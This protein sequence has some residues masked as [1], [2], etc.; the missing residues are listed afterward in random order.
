[1]QTESFADW[2]EQMLKI[3]EAEVR[4]AARVIRSGKL[5][6]YGDGSASGES[7]CA[8]LERELAK[9]MGVEYALVVTSGTAALICAMAGMGI[10]PGDE[11]IVPGYTFMAS[12]LA[13]LAVGAIPVIADIDES[14]TLDPKDVEAKISPRTRAIMPVDMIGLPADMGAIMR[15][16]RRH[17]IA[18]VEDACQADGGWYKGRRLGSIGEVGTYSFNYFK[19]VTCGEGGALVTNDRRVFERAMI[20]HDGGATFRPHSKEIGVPFFAGWNFRMTDILAAIV[21]VQLRRVDGLLA[22]NRA[23]K[24][25]LIHALADHPGISFIKHNDLE[26]DC[27]LVLGFSFAE[28]KAARSFSDAL[29]AAR[30]SAWLPIDSG[31]HVYTN[32]EPIM[33]RRGSYHPALDAYRR[34]ENKGAQMKCTAATCPRTLDTLARTVFLPI[35]HEWKSRD[36]GTVIRACRR[37]ADAVAG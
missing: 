27:G 29:A 13:P 11:V 19:N 15:V 37:A 33:E 2:R 17:R 30:V 5:F 7:E 23:H 21:R 35:R 26:G 28:A 12:A 20:H 6:R 3:G 34:R 22:R 4:A 24:I 10:G 18:V 16:A 31:R 25:R 36:L 32:W 8:K 1:M 9:K 14:L